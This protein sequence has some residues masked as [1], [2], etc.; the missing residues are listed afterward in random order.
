MPALAHGARVVLPVRDAFSPTVVTVRLCTPARGTSSIR[1]PGTAARR[2]PRTPPRY[3]RDCGGAA[4]AV[5]AGWP[6]GSEPPTQPFSPHARPTTGL[7]VSGGSWSPLAAGGPSASEAGGRGGAQ[8]GGL[9]SGG[10]AASGLWSRPAGLPARLLGPQA[11]GRGFWG[12]R[13]AGRAG[14]GP[15]RTDAALPSP[16]NRCV[17]APGRRT[18]APPCTRRCARPDPP[19]A[20]PP[21]PPPLT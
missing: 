15:R 5:A 2:R 20:R 12:P 10:G 18:D 1:G 11:A 4:D 9:A 3:P 16:A 21:A 19:A 6:H 7:P 8:S 13:A 14:S 17:W